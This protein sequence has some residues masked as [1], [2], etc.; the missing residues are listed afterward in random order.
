MHQ[1]EYII[2]E[3][4]RIGVMFLDA[5]V[6]FMIEKAVEHIVRVAHADIDDL[7]M[8]RRVLIGNMRM[9][10]DAGLLCPREGV[11]PE[12]GCLTVE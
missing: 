8:E 11:R 1:S 10:K 4:R 6:G 7:R 2:R 5:K 12:S 9:K 3:A